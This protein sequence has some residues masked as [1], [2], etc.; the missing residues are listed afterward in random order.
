MLIVPGGSRLDWLFISF[1]A[2]V[3]DFRIVSY[4]IDHIV[5]RWS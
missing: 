3:K 2:N 5:S 4:H 1:W